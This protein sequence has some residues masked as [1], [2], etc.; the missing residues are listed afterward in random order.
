MMSIKALFLL[1][2]VLLA[3]VS[4]QSFAPA[5]IPG[6]ISTT[7]S[8]SLDACRI[9]A[10]KEKRKRNRENMRGFQK[11]GGSRRKTLKR[12]L[13]ND[14]RQIE[15]EFIAKCFITIPPPDPKADGMFGDN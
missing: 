12:Q 2:A 7:S 4:V 6:K 8:T 15:D 3:A 13:S 1:V 14:Q 5:F 11:R 10:K 9:S